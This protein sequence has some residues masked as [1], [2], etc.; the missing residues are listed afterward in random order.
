M[1]T[2]MS[3]AGAEFTPTLTLRHARTYGEFRRATLPRPESVTFDPQRKELYV[4]TPTNHQVVI[5][6]QNLAPVFRFQHYVRDGRGALTP[7]E[8]GSAMAGDRGQILITDRVSDQLDVTD[9]RGKPLRSIDLA[10][11][12]GAGAAVHPGRMDRDS[13][14]QLYVVEETTQT[15]LVLSPEGKLLRRVGADGPPP[16]GLQ[17]LADVAV[18]PDGSVVL[19]NATAEPAVRVFDAEGKY[20]T[21]WGERSDKP[22]GLHMSVGV[23]VDSA[24]RI[25]VADTVAHEVKA[26]TRDG[27]V[28]AI[29]GGM[30]T[31]DGRFY[32]PSDVACGADNA[33]YV[34]ERGGDRLQAFQVETVQEAQAGAGAAP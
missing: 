1:A 10:A 20:E 32:F 23:A 27:A 5:L 33:L 17:M 7:G 24:G 15:V 22:E 3:R 4:T 13:A 8:P 16:D 6:N 11:S 19:L 21:G 12:L 2:G 14:G 25:W 30:G 28:L 26:F 29:A 34:T 31:A 18:A 9:F